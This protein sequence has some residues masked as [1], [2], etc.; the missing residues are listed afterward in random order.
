MRKRSLLRLSIAWSLCAA[1]AT[2]AFASG[3][4]SRRS[5]PTSRD[6][7]QQATPP[8]QTSGTSRS[9][10]YHLAR[11]SAFRM[12][13]SSNVEER[14]RGVRRLA[15]QNNTDSTLFLVRCVQDNPALFSDNRVKL[16]AVRALS[17][18]VSRDP[19]RAILTRWVLE[20]TTGQQ[21][22]TGLGHRVRQEAA[23]AL[24]SSQDSRAVELLVDMIAS[25]SSAAEVA[26]HALQA[27]PPTNL[28]PLLSVR[29]LASASVVEL[30]GVLGDFR[31][32][33]PLR[34]ALET[35]DLPVRTAAATALAR[36][37]DEFPVA[38]AR[39]W[40][41]QAGSTQA[42]R[43]AA[44]RTLIFARAAEAPKGVAILLADPSSRATA[45]QLALDAPSP[46]LSPSLAGFL[47]IASPAEMATTLVALARGGGPIA[48]STLERLATSADPNPDAVFALAYCPSPEA[49]QAL[50]RLIATPRTRRMG[51][52]GALVRRAIVRDSPDN[53]RQALYALAS[54]SLSADRELAAFGLTLGRMEPVER[55]IALG[56]VAS[57][58]GACRA[59][60][61]LDLEERGRCARLLRDQMDPEQVLAAVG[62]LRGDV[63]PT[64]LSSDALLRWAESSNRA[65][66]VFA[67][68][69]GSRDDE[70]LHERIRRLFSAGDPVLRAQLAL[71]LAASP[72]PPAIS[73]L[74]DGY[75]FEPDPLVRRAIVRALSATSAPQ[76]STVLQVAE[77]L[78]PDLEV[79][80]L[81]RLARAGVHL[82]TPARGTEMAWIML[83]TNA[84]ATSR[85]SG[86]RPALI[87]P[88]NGFA[89]ATVSD[90][91]GHVLVPGL[92]A[93]QV[94]VLLAPSTTIGQAQP[95]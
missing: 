70:W 68:A 14:I 6:R 73:L 1:I 72:F 39:S 66:A 3:A 65:A 26:A 81:A 21:Q 90:D 22:P 56:D 36:L 33:A 53:L 63:S 80:E 12:L 41:E 71:G 75:A 24:A 28:A 86:S 45:L 94:R 18:L 78:D 74:V 42:V 38:R 60:L 83:D 50:G 76:R 5:R 95:P 87:L 89:I 19:V 30:L 10:A 25:G 2:G 88:S 34:M 49:S 47:A 11:A 20:E 17:P 4:Q 15:S 9:L 54:S 8:T 85:P 93:G 92:P 51:V 23:M 52:R 7:S 79:R 16:E 67:R 69:L 31:A 62:A 27:H 77:H 58:R 43:E 37:G 82:S 84:P 55:F 29:A 40:L 32:I 61:G 13:N 64:D 44:V 48:V 57:L 35:A 59:T 91:D 46:Q